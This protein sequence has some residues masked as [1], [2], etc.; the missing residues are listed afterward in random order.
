M[1]IFLISRVERLIRE[2][3]HAII[4]RIEKITTAD[5]RANAIFT[6]VSG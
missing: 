6:S 1:R 2:K 5:A 4:V 3:S